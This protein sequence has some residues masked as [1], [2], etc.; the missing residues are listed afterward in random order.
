M[1][2]VLI[3]DVANLLLQVHGSTCGHMWFLRDNGVF[4]HLWPP[5]LDQWEV[6]IIRRHAMLR[7]LGCVCARACV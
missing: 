4:V 7:H 2:S 5:T 3:I 6:Q 1:P